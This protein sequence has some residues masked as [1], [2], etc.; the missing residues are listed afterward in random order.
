MQIG[1]AMTPCGAIMFVSFV[2][3]KIF[4]VLFGYLVRSL[5]WQR[6]SISGLKQRFKVFKVFPIGCYF[7][8]LVLS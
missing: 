1:P 6:S 4:P 7:R 5:T 8:Y 2:F 3:P